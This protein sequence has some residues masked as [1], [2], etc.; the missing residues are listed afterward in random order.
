MP[1]NSTR[2]A[3][4]RVG[5]R[6]KAG[7][8][9]HRCKPRCLLARFRVE[10]GARLDGLRCHS[11][12]WIRSSRYVNC[13]CRRPRSDDRRGSSPC[14]PA[15]R[16]C[17]RLRA[18]LGEIRLAYAAHSGQ[19]I[20]HCVSGGGRLNVGFRD[21]DRGGSSDISGGFRRRRSQRRVQAGQDGG[22]AH[23]RGPRG[24]LV[25]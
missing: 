8:D 21:P 24:C 6:R 9:R 10:P 2:G 12:L 3:A 25:Q 13:S 7:I 1:T 11:P 17:F 4:R 18:A 19:D 5:W 15:I 20:S 23:E 22:S 14:R 16:R